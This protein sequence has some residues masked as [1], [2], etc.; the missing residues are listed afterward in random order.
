MKSYLVVFFVFCF[1]LSVNAEEMPTPFGITLGQPI[2]F[3]S[4]NYEH[5]KNFNGFYRCTVLPPKPVEQFE[6]YYI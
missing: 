5:C 4:G 3:Q 2:S 1:N 6:E